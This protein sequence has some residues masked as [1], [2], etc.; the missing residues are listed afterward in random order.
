MRVAV[1]ILDGLKM[2]RVVDE[3]SFDLEIAICTGAE[4]DG[5]SVVHEPML[6][7]LSKEACLA[8]VTH[9]LRQISP[10]VHEAFEPLNVASL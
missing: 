8:A 10:R 9:L 3:Q 6:F 7:P 5:Y 1:P 4:R 2:F